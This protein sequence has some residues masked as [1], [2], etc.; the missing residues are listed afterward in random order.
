MI[1]P[2]GKNMTE[3]NSILEA[4][5]KPAVVFT[6]SFLF[7]DPKSLWFGAELE[8]SVPLVP[9]ELCSKVALISSDSREWGEIFKDKQQVLPIATRIFLPAQRSHILAVINVTPDSFS[10]AG[11]YH[12]KEG[13]FL[14]ER[15]G[16]M[17]KAGVDLIDIGGQSTRPNAKLI[18]AEEEAGRVLPAIKAVKKAWPDCLI[19]CDTSAASVA[20]AALGAGADLINAVAPNEELLRVVAREKCPIILM[21][22]RGDPTAMLKLKEYGDSISD[23]VQSELSA[24]V[25]TAQKLGIP[26]WNIIVD[27]GIGFAKGGPENISLLKALL[28]GDAP[29]LFT[30]FPQC[31]GHS[32]KQFI[33]SITGVPVPKDRVIGSVAISTLFMERKTFMLRVHDYREHCQARLMVEALQ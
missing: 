3:V 33:G 32:R 30:K 20:T 22:S 17:L 5:R 4:L 27:P 23:T 31:V 1:G 7:A 13:S 12:G 19:S 6:T 11:L 2:L 24:W 29:S 26:A 14:T 8:G 28:R 21:H 16:D 25:A 9:D 10:D 15:V 18:S